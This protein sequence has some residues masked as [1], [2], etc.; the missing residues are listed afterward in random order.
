VHDRAILH[1]CSR[2]NYS[3]A[4]D[5]SSGERY[6]YHYDGL[7]SVVA[8][9]NNSGNI[10]EQYR[11][12]VFGTPTILSPSGEPRA[13]SDYKPPKSKIPLPKIPVIPKRLIDV[14][15]L[16]IYTPKILMKISTSA[17]VPQF[18]NFKF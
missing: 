12:D 7:G 16:P 3:K 6:Y 5:V 14:R 15:Q 1:R 17:G 4:V 8:L 10:V 9:S 2:G 11:Y 13:T 18:L